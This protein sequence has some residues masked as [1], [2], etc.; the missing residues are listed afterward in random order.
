M[1]YLLI[2]DDKG[3]VYYC[4]RLTYFLMQQQTMLSGMKCFIC[5]AYQ[6]RGS[7]QLRPLRQHILKS[8][9]RIM[10][11]CGENFTTIELL[12]RHWNKLVS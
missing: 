6:A 1:F 4:T 10:C 2:G 11:K 7:H 9:M 12:S 8:L 5:K 3:I